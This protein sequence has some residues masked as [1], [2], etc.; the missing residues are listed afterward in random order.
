MNRVLIVSIWVCC[1][2]LLS[3]AYEDYLATEFSVKESHGP[4]VVKGKETAVWNILGNYG[5]EQEYWL[6]IDGERVPVTTRE[7][8]KYEVNDMAKVY[9]TKHGYVMD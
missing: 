7:F 2:G 9:Q 6:L 8:R 5:A 4:V 3:L 1:I